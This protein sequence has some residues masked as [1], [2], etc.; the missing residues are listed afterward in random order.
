MKLIKDL[1][2]GLFLVLCVG[3]AA[4]LVG[5]EGRF[6]LRGLDARYIGIGHSAS[7][8]LDTAQTLVGAT[9]TRVAFDGEI[10]DNDNEHDD[11]TTKGRFTAGLAGAYQVSGTLFFDGKATDVYIQIYKNADTSP[12]P[13]AWDAAYHAGEFKGGLNANNFAPTFCITVNLAATDYVEVFA[14][15]AAGGDLLAD[16]GSPAIIYCHANFRRVGE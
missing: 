7:V 1:S 3:V 10:W 9:L 6:T 11:T 15:H 8:Y 5:Q 16:A 13:T 2:V 4:L 14:Y 12:T